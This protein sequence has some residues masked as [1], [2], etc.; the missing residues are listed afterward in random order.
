LAAKNNFNRRQRHDNHSELRAREDGQPLE[1]L[2]SQEK[3][4]PPRD[5]KAEVHRFAMALD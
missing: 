1:R 3:P 4:S 5:C 2:H